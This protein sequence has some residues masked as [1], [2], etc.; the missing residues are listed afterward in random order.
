MFT[1]QPKY[2]LQKWIHF[3]RICPVFHALIFE[4]PLV[5][6]F[7]SI[8][9]EIYIINIVALCFGGSTRMKYTGIVFGFITN[10]QTT[11]KVCY[12]VQQ[13]DLRYNDTTTCMFCLTNLNLYIGD[14]TTTIH[15][16]H[17]RIITYYIKANI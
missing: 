11:T 17:K 14:Q 4:F 13:Q 9:A 6:Y 8:S 3:P 7:T 12:P 16:I 15:F 10:S 2:K 1:I 5:H